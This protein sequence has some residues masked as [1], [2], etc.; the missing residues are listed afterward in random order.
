MTVKHS[1]MNLKSLQIELNVFREEL[2]QN[3]KELNDGKEELKNVKDEM[4]YLKEK[5]T[6]EDP[7]LNLENEFTCEI[8]DQSFRSKKSLKMHNQT[9]HTPRIK[10]KSCDETFDKTCKSRITY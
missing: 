1:K 9:N 8:C 7:K 3:R 4:K 5:E 2:K 6:A 10:C